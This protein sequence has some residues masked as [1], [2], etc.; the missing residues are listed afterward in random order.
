MQ[1]GME[2][3][4]FDNA[5]DGNANRGLSANMGRLAV[6]LILILVVLQ[7]AV[8]V[9]RS[10]LGET[11]LWLQESVVYVH[12]AIIV[13]AVGWTLAEDRHVRIDALKTRMGSSLQWRVEQIGLIATAVASA[14]ILFL[15]WG[16]V[17]ASWRMLE[18]SREVGGLPGLFVL[19]TLMPLL[20]ILL[21]TAALR[22]LRAVS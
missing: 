7:F 17:T 22:R 15:S 6:P 5:S 13:F 11:A 21:G 3:A 10:L 2:N 16:F 12:A 18:G 1:G 8:I 20:V 14:F 9:A 4:S 19:K